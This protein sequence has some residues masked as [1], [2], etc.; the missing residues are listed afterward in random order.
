MAESS[1]VAA[2]LLLT[3]ALL[4]GCA[5]GTAAQPAE[6]RSTQDPHASASGRAAPSADHAATLASLRKVDDHPLWTMRYRGGYDR[7]AEIA[8]AL[9]PTG[10]GCS[11]FSAHGDPAA[12][13]FGR[14]F[15]YDHQ[16]ALL[17][18]T[19]PPDGH[20]SVS[21]VDVSYLGLKSEADFT[22]AA[23]RSALLQAPLLPFDGMNSKG[24]V[25]GMATVPSW[26]PGSDPARRTVGSVRIM[27][28]V[29]DGAAT[30]DE[31]LAV[32]GRHNIDPSDS[33]PLHYMVA[34]AAGRSAVV[35]FVD[36]EMVVHRGRGPW[37]AMVNFAVTGS[38]EQSRQADH[39]YRTATA[40][41]EAAGGGLSADR[42]MDLLARLRQGHT[43]WS[44]VY[45]GKSG[46][47][48]LATGRRY[49]TVHEFRLPMG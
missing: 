31:A 19:T 30:V 8:P 45:G 48:R 42:A 46:E 29:L 37:Q 20:A 18:F 41:L 3:T 1:R 16:P 33:P 38:T 44:I 6:R 15:D 32:F 47:V 43:Q 5:S 24:L 7:F 36:G 4:A 17:L 9:T 26:R 11:L 22:T 2:A 10:F 35:E 21:M 27:R 28:L 23:G 14:N 25:V 40:A 39:R 49:G 34:D 12:P 13:V